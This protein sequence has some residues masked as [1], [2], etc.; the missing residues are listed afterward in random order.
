MML[1]EQWAKINYFNPEEEWGD[2]EQMSYLLLIRLD[3]LRERAGKPIIIHSGFASSGYSPNSYHYLGMATDLHIEGLSVL[4]Q[5]LL[6]EQEGFGGIGVYPYWS[7][8]GLHLD[9][10]SDGPTRWA[11]V[12]G[13]YV[14]LTAGVFK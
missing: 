9:T 5:Y 7:S 8:P 4:D 2:P 11:R 13:S 12:D 3:S 10:R 1:P 6:A 14:S